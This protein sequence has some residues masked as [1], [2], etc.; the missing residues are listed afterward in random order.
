MRHGGLHIRIHMSCPR[1]V[2]FECAQNSKAPFDI[3]LICAP[4]H[5]PGKLS[6][7]PLS[8]VALWRYSTFGGH[9][10][11]HRRTWRTLLHGSCV[12]TQLACC[13]LHRRIPMLLLLLLAVYMCIPN[14]N[15]INRRDLL[16]GGRDR[17]SHSLTKSYHQFIKG[18]FANILECRRC[19]VQHTMSVL[20]DTSFAAPAV[21]AAVVYKMMEHIAMC[22][23]CICDI[24]RGY[25]IYRALPTKPVSQN[26]DETFVHLYRPLKWKKGSGSECEFSTIYNVSVYFLILCSFSPFHPNPP[27]H[28][29]W[30]VP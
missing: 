7:A 27:T 19:R 21:P 30:N 24:R 5:S 12:L 22:S 14:I 16:S 3:L 13:C 29:T 26:S 17:M 1:A 25:C 15:L 9:Y 8:T 2:S 28:I 10:F 18:V 6:S 4:S 20:I 11:S 23:M